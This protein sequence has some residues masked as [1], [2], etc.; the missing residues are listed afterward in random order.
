M[1]RMEA[2][3]TKG[4]DAVAN[5]HPPNVIPVSGTEEVADHILIVQYD[6]KAKAFGRAGLTASIFRSQL[7]EAF[8]FNKNVQLQLHSL[9]DSNLTAYSEEQ[10]ASLPPGR[11]LLTKVVETHQ[12]SLDFQ[13]PR[14]ED[15]NNDEKTQLFRLSYPNVDYTHNVAVIC[16]AEIHRESE[17]HYLVLD[18]LINISVKDFEAQGIFHEQVEFG[19]GASGLRIVDAQPGYEAK[20]FVLNRTDS[21]NWEVSAGGTVSKDPSLNAG[22][23]YG[24]SSSIASTYQLDEWDTAIKKEFSSNSKNERL[25]LGHSWVLTLRDKA[26]GVSTIPSS[27]CYGFQ[28]SFKVK[29]QLPPGQELK[30]LFQPTMKLDMHHRN[31]S[32]QAQN[33]EARL[34]KLQELRDGLQS[35][36]KGETQSE[37]KGETKEEERLKKLNYSIQYYSRKHQEL[38]ANLHNATIPS[39][40][41]QE[42]SLKLPLHF[43]F[44][45]RHFRPGSSILDFQSVARDRGH[46]H[47]VKATHH[48]I[49]PIFI[50][51][52][53]NLPS[54]NVAL[55][56]LILVGGGTAVA[57]PGGSV[58]TA[59]SSVGLGMPYKFGKSMNPIEALAAKSAKAL[60]AFEM[61]ALQ[62]NENRKLQLNLL[63]PMFDTNDNFE[64][65]VT[66]KLSMLLKSMSDR[67]AGLNI[68]S[69]QRLLVRHKCSSLQ[70]LDE[71]Q[72][73]LKNKLL[74]TEFAPVAHEI[75]K[76]L[77]F[78]PQNIY[79]SKKLKL[80]T[81]SQ[82]GSSAHECYGAISGYCAVSPIGTQPVKFTFLSCNHCFHQRHHLPC[83]YGK[84][85]PQLC[86]YSRDLR[87]CYCI[88]HDEYSVEL[89]G[90]V[91]SSESF[92][93]LDVNQLP[94]TPWANA[95]CVA[96]WYMDS[97]TLAHIFQQ[98]QADMSSSFEIQVVTPRTVI[99]I[100]EFDFVFHCE[101]KT[102]VLDMSVPGAYFYAICSLGLFQQ[103][104]SGSLLVI[105]DKMSQFS[106]IGILCA[107]EDTTATLQQVYFMAM[108]SCFDTLSLCGLYRYF[109][110]KAKFYFLP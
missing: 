74:T 11:Y 10:A 101:E 8:H 12:Q 80:L 59:G 90:D 14:A 85:P 1:S 9:N 76:R 72:Q 70:D 35:E 27:A 97:S 73:N 48:V 36:Q 86:T 75:F 7:L 92:D 109:D 32:R 42:I 34:A 104:D 58:D 38:K 81:S 19:V 107:V 62:S 94:R 40:E 106:P 53:A 71:L 78:I 69:R 63:E 102:N 39:Q 56:R 51:E 15:W 103:G 30:R 83:R 87:K 84:D 23:K 49:L 20:T 26:H 79:E 95:N 61:G 60:E 89:F 44:H 105:K 88:H 21:S 2:K 13:I 45:V 5:S 29:F 52:S 108:K 50:E 28:K 37:Q 64:L 46:V 24:E 6:G 91:A 31:L 55:K 18:F 96:G 4:N 93:V 110:D 41:S 98:F 68:M 16:L 17:Y 57:S 47:L 99:N 66:A 43:K 3:E 54:P 65:S 77:K 25:W 22:I 100:S 67:I 82:F 33:V